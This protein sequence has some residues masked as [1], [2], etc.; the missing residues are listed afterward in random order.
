MD[1]TT[2]QEAAVEVFG[3]ETGDH[4]CRK[5]NWEM[6]EYL[7]CVTETD[8]TWYSEIFGAAKVSN[9]PEQHRLQRTTT[10]HHFE[11]L[12]QAKPPSSRPLVSPS[13]L[14]AKKTS[15]KRPRTPSPIPRN[16]RTSHPPNHKP[17][18]SSLAHAYS[19]PPSLQ[20]E[21]AILHQTPSKRTTHHL[22]TT[23]PLPFSPQ[24]TRLQSHPLLLALLS[25]RSTQSRI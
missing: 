20:K 25:L 14:L 7:D 6:F 15:A 4:L 5:G 21:V 11:S 18:I 2:W 12:F 24:Q 22:N 3:A 17:K 23:F 9:I 10:H 16:T 1:W 13:Q 19:R 8:Y